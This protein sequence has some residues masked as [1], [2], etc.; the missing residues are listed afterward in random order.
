MATRKQKLTSDHF[1]KALNPRDADTKYM[2]SEPFFPR[3]P[4][5]EQRTTLLTQG[6]TWYNRFYGKKDARDLLCQYLDHHNR[7]DEAKKI[8]EEGISIAHA[9]NKQKTLS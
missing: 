3:Q 6:F 1:V 7:T 8:Y 5:T 2:G 4:E 9:Q